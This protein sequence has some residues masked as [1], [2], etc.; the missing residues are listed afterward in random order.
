VTEPTLDQQIRKRK[1]EN[2]ERLAAEKRVSADGAGAGSVQ[3][4][5]SRLQ[6]TPLAAVE[7]RSV[8]WLKPGLIPLG[9]LTLAGPGRAGS[10][11][12]RC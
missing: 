4:R 6:L 1:E 9:A 3:V 8:R 10:G 7:A 2:A 5:S 12:R 11:N